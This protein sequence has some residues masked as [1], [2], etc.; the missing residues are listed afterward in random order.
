MLFRTITLTK[1]MKAIVDPEDYDIIS[2]MKW[3]V[4]N[5]RGQLRALHSKRN[6]SKINTILMSRYIM[7]CPENMVVD[8]INHN[9]LDNRRCN[10]RICTRSENMRNRVSH[11]CKGV[12]RH[13]SKWR[14][15]ITINGETI[16]IGDFIDKQDA[17]LAY[18]NAAIQYHGI[19]ANTNYV[20]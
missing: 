6:G 10:L 4:T 5:S 20:G 13:Y 7:D 2:G 9:T 19:F 11:G 8:H 15:R 18:N 3:C 1:G 16:I 14:S 12:S 17:I